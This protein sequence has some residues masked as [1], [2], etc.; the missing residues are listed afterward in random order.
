M[1]VFGNLKLS[2]MT[3]TFKCNNKKCNKT[4]ICIFTKYEGSKYL[5]RCNYCHSGRLEW[6]ENVNI[7]KELREQKIIHTIKKHGE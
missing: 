2:A 6:I 1:T 7:H 3:Y 4:I 5:D